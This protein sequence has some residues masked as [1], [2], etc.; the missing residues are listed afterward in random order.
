LSGIFD[1]VVFLCKSRMFRGAP[2]FKVLV[3]GSKS[4]SCMLKS[5][6]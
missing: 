6:L 3:K 5:R 2:S 1:V 4:S